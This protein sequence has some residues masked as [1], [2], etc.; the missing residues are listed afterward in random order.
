MGGTWKALQGTIAP[1]WSTPTLSLLLCALPKSVGL[2]EKGNG[3]R[4]FKCTNTS[5]WEWFRVS[6][7]K[8]VPTHPYI[9]LVHHH[10][11]AT[12]IKG[13][14]AFF[15][16]WVVHWPRINV[17]QYSSLGP[18]SSSITFPACISPRKYCVGQIWLH[19][20]SKGVGAHMYGRTLV[21][22]MN[23]LVL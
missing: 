19:S 6:K 17:L 5:P 20:F 8:H 22:T 15:S 11:P 10:Q 13:Y 23:S 21:P 7:L 2:P 18:Y 16:V 9:H 1:F 3:N 4:G 14:F 12:W